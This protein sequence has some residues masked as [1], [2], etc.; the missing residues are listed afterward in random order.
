MLKNESA[1]NPTKPTPLHSARLPDSGGIFFLS[2]GVRGEDIAFCP[3][4]QTDNFFFFADC[5]VRTVRM[6]ADVAGPYSDTWQVHTGHMAAPGADTCQADL[7]FLVYGWTNP[8]VTRVTTGRVTH[9]TGDVS[10]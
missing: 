1:R 8:E 5:S 3:K 2:N 7:D 4:S 10:S 9:G 6:D